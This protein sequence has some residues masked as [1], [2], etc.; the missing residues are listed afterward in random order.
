MSLSYWDD[1][2][3]VLVIYLLMLGL[4]DSLLDYRMKELHLIYLIL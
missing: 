2:S 4:V 1:L 3:L